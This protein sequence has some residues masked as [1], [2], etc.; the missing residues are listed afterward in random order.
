VRT[1]DGFYMRLAIGGGALSSTD[2][3]GGGRLSLDIKGAGPAFDMMFGGTLSGGVVLGGG[4]VFQQ[5]TKPTY[6]FLNTEAKSENNVSF[7]VLGPFID[8]FPDP[9]G[10]FHFGGLLGAAILT[11]DDAS[12]TSSS[13]SS[14]TTASASGT[15]GALFGG[16]DVWV[17]DQWSLGVLLRAAAG[18]TK[19]DSAATTL[20]QTFEEKQSTSTFAVLFSVLDH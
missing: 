9:K 2:D 15:G 11:V 3:V 13:S 19:T 6:K 5:A 18:S 16:Y 8:W 4:M 14:T 12:G 10:G 1:H 7:G 20:G 17:A